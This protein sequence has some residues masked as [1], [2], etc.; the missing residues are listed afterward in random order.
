MSKAPII[1]WLLVGLALSIWGSNYLGI[2]DD[3][4]V[5]VKLKSDPEE[6]V[7]N[8]TATLIKVY[9][10]R[11]EIGSTTTN[12][13]GLGW[14]RDIEDGIYHVYIKKEGYDVYIEV[15]R[16]RYVPYPLQEFEVKY[17]QVQDGRVFL[18]FYLAPK[19]PEAE[20]GKDDVDG[21]KKEEK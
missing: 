10:E 2:P 21:D 5:F 4:T 3:I 20:P 6:G 13:D 18:F 9:P 11:K 17:G 16:D 1:F 7:E 14:F 19:P 8:V 12:K 15:E